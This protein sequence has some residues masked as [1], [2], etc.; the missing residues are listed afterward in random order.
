MTG[1]GIARTSSTR[2]SNFLR[3]DESMVLNFIIHK[4]VQYD[5]KLNES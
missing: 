2:M 5:I 4:A 1:F 3:F